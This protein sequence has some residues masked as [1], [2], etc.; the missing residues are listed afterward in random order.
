MDNGRP[1]AELEFANGIRRGLG[2]ELQALGSTPSETIAFVYVPADEDDAR[3]RL[4]PLGLKC[5]CRVEHGIVRLV[6]SRLKW[7]MLRRRDRGR[8]KSLWE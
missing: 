4:I 8:S 3:N 7:Y 5:S 1:A 6:A 2:I